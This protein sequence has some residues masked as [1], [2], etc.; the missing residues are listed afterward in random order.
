MRPECIRLTSCLAQPAGNTEGTQT[1]DQQ[2]AACWKGYRC[3]GLKLS[4]SD[5]QS[6]KIASVGQ[7]VVYTTG[8]EHAVDDVFAQIERE[9]VL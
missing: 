6:G 1:A 2:Q 4:R 9:N 7:V 5:R 3:E 8:H